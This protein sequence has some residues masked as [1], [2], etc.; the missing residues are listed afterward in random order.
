MSISGQ[1]PLLLHD[2]MSKESQFLNSNCALQWI[3][4]GTIFVEASK[5]VHNFLLFLSTWAGNKDIVNIAV[6]KRKT[7]RDLVNKTLKGLSGVAK[8]KWHFQKILKV[9]K[10]L[11]WPSYGY[12]QV[13]LGSAGKLTPDPV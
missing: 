3:Y 12:Q 1:I 7:T 10:G 13:P 2:M 8:T 11:F 5:T 6:H 9:R 4:D